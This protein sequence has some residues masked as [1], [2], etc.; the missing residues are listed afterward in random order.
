MQKYKGTYEPF[1]VWHKTHFG[2]LMDK[3]AGWRFLIWFV[4]PFLVGV[5]AF[6][7]FM[8]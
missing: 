5:L 1:F 6:F 8:R 7:K 2:D 4:I 3:T